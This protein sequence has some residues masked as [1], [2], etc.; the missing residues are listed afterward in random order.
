MMCDKLSLSVRELG[1]EEGGKFRLTIFD[2]DRLE[3]FRFRMFYLFLF[4]FSR[5]LVLR[6]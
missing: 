1:K 2:V 3:L 5:I 4:I 6:T